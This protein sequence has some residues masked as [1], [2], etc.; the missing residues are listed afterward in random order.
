MQKIRGKRRT[1]QRLIALGS[2]ITLFCIITAGYAP[3]PYAPSKI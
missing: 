1:K 2:I 3:Y